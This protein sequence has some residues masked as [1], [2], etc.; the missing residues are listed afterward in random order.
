MP[1]HP[2]EPSVETTVK[3]ML[4]AY[5]PDASDEAKRMADRLSM[6]ADHNGG[7]FWHQVHVALQGLQLEPASRAD[8]QAA[9]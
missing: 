5:G 7:D 1:R 2:K 8:L 3:A 4:R 9:H 6:R